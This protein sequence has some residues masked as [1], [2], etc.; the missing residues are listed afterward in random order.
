MIGL[1]EKSE[2]RQSRWDESSGHHGCL[3]QISLQSILYLWR[4]FSPD[5]CDGPTDQQTLLNLRAWLQT[6]LKNIH[7]FTKGKSQWQ[8]VQCKHK[9]ARHWERLMISSAALTRIKTWGVTASLAY[10]HQSHSTTC[11]CRLWAGLLANKTSCADDKVTLRTHSL[12]AAP[13]PIT[14]PT[15]HLNCYAGSLLV[16]TRRPPLKGW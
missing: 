11:M 1:S 5:Q 15:S 9:H 7:S 8:H 12:S 4:C 13:F 6:G 2:D 14:Q 10:K 16:C 3:Y